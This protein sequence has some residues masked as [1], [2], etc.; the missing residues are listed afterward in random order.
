MIGH[1]GPVDALDIAI[2]GFGN[3]EG[4][5]AH[6]DGVRACGREEF[7]TEFV[8]MDE[9]RPGIARVIAKPA[10]L[11]AF[12]VEA[13]PAVEAGGVRPKMDFQGVGNVADEAVF[14]SCGP[15]PSLPGL[16]QRPSALGLAVLPTN[17]TDEEAAAFAGCQ[18]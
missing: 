15:G 11:L 8:L 18:Q 9:R 1:G 13:D 14:A 5:I 17:P 4:Q 3:R 2:G 12:E 6:A 10:D 7:E 16:M